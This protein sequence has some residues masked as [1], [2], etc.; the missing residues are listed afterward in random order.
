MPTAVQL[1]IHSILCDVLPDDDD[2][3]F[4]LLKRY[5]KNAQETSIISARYLHKDRDS[6]LSKKATSVVVSVNRDDV[7]K[8]L[9]GIFLFSEGRK[10]E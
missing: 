8:L 5:I 10:V 3:L 4:P 6:R 2:E 9:S 7:E 1:A